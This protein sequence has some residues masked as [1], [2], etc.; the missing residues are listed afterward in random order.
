MELIAVV[1]A[2][3]AAVSMADSLHHSASWEQKNQ[4]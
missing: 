2:V 1:V 4:K 3:A